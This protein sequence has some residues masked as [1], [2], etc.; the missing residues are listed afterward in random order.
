M[1]AIFKQE[2]GVSAVSKSSTGGKVKVL[3]GSGAKKAKAG[4]K[5]AQKSNSA[6]KSLMRSSSGNAKKSVAQVRTDQ[7]TPGNA[8][9]KNT[10]SITTM[11]DFKKLV[12]KISA[13]KK[14]KTSSRK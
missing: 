1:D 14:Q 9:A 6:V 11:H 5:S 4:K 7:P 8:T 12:S 13:N 3:G 10:S 2:R